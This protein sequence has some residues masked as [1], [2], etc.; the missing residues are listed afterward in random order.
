MPRVGKSETYRASAWPSHVKRVCPSAK[1]LPR[2][3]MAEPCQKS[4][5]FSQRFAAHQHGQAITIVH[6]LPLTR[7]STN[8][9]RYGSEFCNTLRLQN[10]RGRHEL[11]GLHLAVS[12]ASGF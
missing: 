2:I 5:S 7:S 6:P 4:L 10:K 1:D 3:S 9:P 12:P 11:N 8:I